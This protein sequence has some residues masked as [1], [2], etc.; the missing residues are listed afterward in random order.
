M[1]AESCSASAPLFPLVTNQDA[2]HFMLDADG[3]VERTLPI[4]EEDYHAIRA[5]F[6]NSK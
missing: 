2:I 6:E 5:E 3:P 4:F 1:G